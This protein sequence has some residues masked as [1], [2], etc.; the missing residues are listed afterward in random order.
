MFKSESSDGGLLNA[1][2]GSV[3]WVP[4][5]PITLQYSNERIEQIVLNLLDNG[6]RGNLAVRH[7]KN[8]MIALKFNM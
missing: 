7:V 5:D 4:Q 1:V 8:S 6:A 2:G 3:F